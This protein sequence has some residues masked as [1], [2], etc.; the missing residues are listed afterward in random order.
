M[1]EDKVINK[2]N[3]KINDLENLNYINEIENLSARIDMSLILAIK[4]D[5]KINSQIKTEIINNMVKVRDYLYTLN[6]NKNNKDKEFNF[7]TLYNSVNYMFYKLNILENFKDKIDEVIINNFDAS[8][9][10]PSAYDMLGNDSKFIIQLS[11]VRSLN[12]II[13]NSKSMV[14]ESDI[15]F[16]LSELINS[17]TKTQKLGM[18][19][20]Y[21]YLNSKVINR[22][23]KNLNS[24]NGGF[25]LGIKS[26]VAN[27]IYNLAMFKKHGIEVTG[28]V[29]LIKE[30]IDFLLKVKKYD[31]NKLPVWERFLS[32]ENYLNIEYERENKIIKDFN[33]DVI[34]NTL[35]IL[36]AIYFAAKELRDFERAQ[37]AKEQFL[38]FCNIYLE[39]NKLK[40]YIVNNNYSELPILLS[41]MNT[42]E[43]ELLLKNIINNLNKDILQKINKLELN[44]EIINNIKVI[45]NLL[46]SIDDD[47]E[48]NSDWILL[49]N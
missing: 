11:T 22:R 6:T 25:D 47:F 21:W 43:K 36:M 13:V 49:S 48:P 38:K 16:I 23:F 35:S 46:I 42:Y 8:I 45:K 28:H 18:I 1:V 12:H 15:K 32:L 40:K 17:F 20:P 7:E 5:D 31:E 10:N 44:D 3:K 2:F 26:G 30:G 37:Y 29:E 19:L 33:I 24:I 4:K 27:L 9:K 14:K 34:N 39:K 41:L